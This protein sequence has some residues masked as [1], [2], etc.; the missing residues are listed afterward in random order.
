MIYLLCDDLCFYQDTKIGVFYKKAN[1]SIVYCIKKVALL[2]RL[3]GRTVCGL[4]VSV[5]CVAT[6]PKKVVI[7]LKYCTKIL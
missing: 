3:G 1:L 6:K 5:L 7:Y 2:Q 4:C